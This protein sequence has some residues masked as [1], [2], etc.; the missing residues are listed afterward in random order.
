MYATSTRVVFVG[1]VKWGMRS[2]RSEGMGLAIA[3]VD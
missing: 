3:V 2:F 1:F